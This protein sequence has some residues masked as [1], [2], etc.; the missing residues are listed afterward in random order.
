MCDQMMG[1]HNMMGGHS[2]MGGHNMDTARMHDRMMA[3]KPGA[4]PQSE[5]TP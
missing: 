2:M 5:A 4:E 1:G 3:E